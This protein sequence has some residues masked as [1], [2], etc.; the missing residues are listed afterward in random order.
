MSNHVS[1]GSI[2]P[3][4]G[5][6]VGTVSTGGIAGGGI[7]T[8]IVSVVEN[9]RIPESIE[10]GLLLSAPYVSVLLGAV[11]ILARVKA[12]D[13][14]RTRSQRRARRVLDETLAD[15]NVDDATKQKVMEYKHRLILS[16]VENVVEQAT[17]PRDR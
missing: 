9:Y 12:S 16:V 1:H 5:L 15:P 8:V 6:G 14:V 13:I 3:R 7:G 17:M 10:T 2:E 11:V 4:N